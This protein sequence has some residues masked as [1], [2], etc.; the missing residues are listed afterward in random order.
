[1]ELVNRKIPRTRIALRKPW[2]I[3]RLLN[4]TVHFH[5]Q[6]R[7]AL[8]YHSIDCKIK[9]TWG[10]HNWDWSNLEQSWIGN[11]AEKDI[12]S[13]SSWPKKYLFS[14]LESSLSISMADG[15]SMSIAF[16]SAGLIDFKSCTV[17]TLD[18]TGRRSVNILEKLLYKDRNNV[19]TW[20]RLV[21]MGKRYGAKS[22]TLVDVT[23][24]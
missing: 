9:K 15:S 21:R 24:N 16:A 3:P 8:S 10:M 22:L 2:H 6:C 4:T 14:G 11:L 20:K 17:C 19:C 18:A 13:L 7:H 12:G 5:L 23:E 1:M